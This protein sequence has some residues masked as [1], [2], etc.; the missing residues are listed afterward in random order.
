M[1]ID[2]TT[3]SVIMATVAAC[4]LLVMAIVHWDRIRPVLFS[5]F[6]IFLVDTSLMF[7]CFFFGKE[8]ILVGANVYVLLEI[9][10]YVRRNDNSCGSTGSLIYAVAIG[11]FNF[12]IQFALLLAQ[13]K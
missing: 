10:D 7:G 6:L 2:Q 8:A 12:A 1:K 9:Y 4:N 13:D 11:V 5:R 3:V